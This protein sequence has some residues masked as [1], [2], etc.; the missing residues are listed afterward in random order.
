MYHVTEA[1]CAGAKRMPLRAMIGI[2]CLYRQR[3][4]SDGIASGHLD[5][6]AHTLAAQKLS[7]SLGRKQLYIG[8]NHAQRRRIQVIVMQMGKQNGVDMAQLLALEGTILASTQK[9]DS[10][11]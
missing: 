9:G 11:A 3:P 8:A 10:I 6:V 2:G 4:N 7:R 5:H 1:L